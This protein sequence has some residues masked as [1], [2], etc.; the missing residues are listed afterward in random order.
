MENESSSYSIPRKFYNHLKPLL[1][2]RKRCKCVKSQHEQNSHLSWVSHGS[3]S[4]R[5]W[6]HACKR[7]WRHGFRNVKWWKLKGF[8]CLKPWIEDVT[9][10]RMFRMKTFK[11]QNVFYKNVSDYKG[12]WK[13]LKNAS[14]YRRDVMDVS[15][16][17]LI[18]FLLQ[19]WCH[20]LLHYEDVSLVYTCDVY[21]RHAWRQ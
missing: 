4:W 2:H 21:N 10:R 18:H 14:C 17:D 13:S 1:E 8:K 20:V 6:R 16:T 19:P 12:K 3:F 11:R 5:Y 7:D 15:K 9:W